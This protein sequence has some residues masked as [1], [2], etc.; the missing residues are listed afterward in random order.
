[1]ILDATARYVMATGESLLAGCGRIGKWLVL[2]WFIVS[3]L[4]RHLGT[5]ARIVL[6]G[7][8]AHFILP[9]PT[10][11][12]VAIWGWAS[13]IAGFALMYWGRYRTVEKFCKPLAVVLG[14]CLAAA[15]ILSEPDVTALLKGAL[16]PSLP[17]REGAY[18]NAILLMAMLSAATGSFSNLKY[19]AYVHDKGW[20]NLSFLR[21]QRFD[22]VLSMCG[23]FVMLAM[24][25]AAAGG[26]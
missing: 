8:A 10:R 24:I 4:K 18:G 22:L 3:V 6:L 16:T 7:A 9:L 15:A 23:M 17:T 2:L 26:S 12:S 25:Q 21:D 11:H 14:A 13:W 20:R 5:L 19:A 1:M